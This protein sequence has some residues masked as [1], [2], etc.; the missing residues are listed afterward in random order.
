M[1]VSYPESAQRNA[2]AHFEEAQMAGRA[3]VKERQSDAARR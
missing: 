2:R 3:D 1:L